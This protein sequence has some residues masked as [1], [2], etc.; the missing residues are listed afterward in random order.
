KRLKAGAAFVGTLV[1]AAVSHQAHSAEK[2]PFCQMS[3]NLGGVNATAKLTRA[4]SN[5]PVQTDVTL[6]RPWP[7]RPSRA[8][9]VEACR[10]CRI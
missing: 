5:K 9:T 2:L 4:G 3:F 1:S 6:S 7:A 8:K 10:T